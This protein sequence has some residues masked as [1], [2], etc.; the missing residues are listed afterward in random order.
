MCFPLVLFAASEK[1]L[2]HKHHFVPPAEVST[3][4]WP[5]L[6]T[7]SWLA[8]QLWWCHLKKKRTKK[9]ISCTFLEGELTESFHIL[10]T[11]VKE[12]NCS[13]ITVKFWWKTSDCFS[14]LVDLVDLIWHN[15]LDASFNWSNIFIIMSVWTVIHANYQPGR[16]SARCVSGIQLFQ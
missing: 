3:S 15:H 11:D 10:Q 14:K 5:R 12:T 4:R 7:A 16:S 13:N 1:E 8:P 9:I 2:L 6:N